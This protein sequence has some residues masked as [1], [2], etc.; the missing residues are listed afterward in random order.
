MPTSGDFYTSN[1]YIFYDIVV[2]E[3]ATSS[4]NNTST[5][6]VVVR[7]WRTNEYV[8]NRDGICYVKVNGEESSSSW[9][10]D[11]HPLDNLHKET[12]YDETI[13]VPHNA[14][15]TMTIYVESWIKIFSGS[16]TYW[17]SRWQGFNV[18]LSNLDG[19]GPTITVSILDVTDNS[20]T[21]I[22][23]A[24]GTTC[25]DWYFTVDKA[26][27]WI[28]FSTESAIA[29]TITVYNLTSGT[30]Y[31]VMACAIKSSN[32]MGGYSDIISVETTGGTARKRNPPLIRLFDAN[33]TT[34]TT[35]GV[36]SLPDAI[37]CIVTEE[38][39]GVF[40]LEMEYPI[41]GLRYSEI[42]HRRI[43][44]VKPNDYASPQPFRIYSVSKPLNGRVKVRAAHISYDL[45]GY[46]AAP[47]SAGT[48]SSALVLLQQASDVENPFIFWTDINTTAAFYN[49]VP[50]SIRSL[51]GGKSGS[52]L[53]TYLGEYEF[54]GY[55]VKLWAERGSN[56]GVTL[57][58]GKNL[59]SLKQDENC[60]NVFT[61]VRPFWYKQLN[62]ENPDYDKEGL[63]ELP[64]KTISVGTFN[65][66]RILALDLTSKFKEKPTVANLRE[67]AEQYIV[68]NNVG[69][70]EISLDVSFIRLSDS[71]EYHNM[72]LL[73]KVQ[74]CDTV[75]VEFP[76]LGVSST[77]KCV[78]TEYNVLSQRYEKLSLGT[79]K[80]DLSKT[81]SIAAN[82]VKKTVTQSGLETAII[83]ATNLITG[84]SGG[85]VVLDP[86]NNPTR[87]LIMDTDNMYTAMDVW[88]WNLEGLG[89]SSN[90]VNGPYDV[91]ITQGGSINANFITS[92]MINGNMIEA[93]TITAGSISQEYTANITNSINSTAD[94]VRQEFIAADAQLSNSITEAYTSMINGDV[95]LLN[96][97]IS[98]LRQSIDGVI[99]SF[100]SQ[101][102]GGINKI[103]NS[104]G[105]NGKSD[106][107]EYTGEVDAIQ[108]AEAASKTVS[109]SLWRIG[110]FADPS[111]SY[112]TQKINTVIGTAYSLTFK[113]KRDTSDE[114]VVLI[115][116]GDDDLIVFDEFASCD[117]T[118]YNYSF[119]AASDNIIL[120]LIAYGHYMYVS[121]LML[122]EGITK[123]NWTPAPNEIYTTNVK[124]DK[125]GINIT[126]SESSTQTI[127]DN[128]QF[129][130]LHN[131]QVVLTV[132][133]DL[134]TL[135]KTEVK[136]ELTIGKC[137]FV[138]NANGL[139]FVVL[140]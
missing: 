129:A 119:T 97:S 49:N 50:T 16:N 2:T 22:V 4:V 89:H 76:E 64:E 53:D 128:T 98:E 105:W 94:T 25:D 135:Q 114:Y 81:I 42:G 82:A 57:R 83:Q 43:I 91:A 140:D 58:Y 90:G 116:N 13:T 60:D 46:T 5:V 30:E 29:Q 101:V 17:S 122:V 12:I 19:D 9:V 39:N 113:C 63:V 100:S 125:R 18:V 6:N 117:W 136:N 112:L 27:T 87:I 138:P 130:V 88:Q 127:I 38:R 20:F 54:D 3:T 59:T 85:Y 65:Y 32:G 34:F 37:S 24:N 118:E 123:S 110:G 61:A 69:S 70:P 111:H 80:A 134:T 68:D 121:D 93:G 33:E 35:N 78:K 56:R 77:A 7:A 139:D 86:P 84:N 52:I 45:S 11:E 95:E 62:E 23:D 31:N 133:K 51:L 28:E 44:L 74:L 109:G 1:E 126:N 66:V 41:S 15:G 40:E 55:N 103:E 102:V 79:V 73:E 71:E 106:D 137:R 48:A 75:T 96:S 36:G 132:N 67:A 104:C 21:M 8:T 92:G 14:D 120:K 124:I 99:M 26:S 10:Y 131:D 47:F 115:D 108:N 107:W 72:A